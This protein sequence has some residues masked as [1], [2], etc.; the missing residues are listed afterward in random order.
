MRFKWKYQ[1]KI[2]LLNTNIDAIEDIIIKCENEKIPFVKKF[3]LLGVIL[4]EYLTFDLHTISI[5]SKVNWKISVLRKS[6]YLFDLKFRVTLFK[7]FI[8]SKYDYCSSL[9]IYFSDVCNLKHQ[10]FADLT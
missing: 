7:L 5:C 4:D 6:S 8:M 2:D 9:F 10:Y 3:T 1:R